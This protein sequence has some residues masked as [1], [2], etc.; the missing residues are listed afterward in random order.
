M[1][2]GAVTAA[3]VVGLATFVYLSGRNKDEDELCGPDP[4]PIGR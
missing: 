4:F 2:I 1:T 3:V